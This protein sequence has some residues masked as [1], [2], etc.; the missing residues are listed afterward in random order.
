MQ[1][2]DCAGSLDFDKFERVLRRMKE[3]GGA[4]GKLVRQGGVGDGEGGEEEVDGVHGARGIAA[5]V[6]ERVR[7]DVMRG[8]LV[9][10]DGE[11]GVLKGR[12]LVIVEGFLLFGRSVPAVLR[13]MFDV[14]V[15]LRARYEDAKR[16][17]ERRNGYVTLEGFW[18]DPP[19]YFDKVVWPNYVAEHGGLV[20]DEE[21]KGVLE[22]SEVGGRVHFSDPGWGLEECLVWV[23]GVMRREVEAINQGSDKS[24]L[25][26]DSQSG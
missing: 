22:G 18:Q 6:V 4:V 19:G 23:L 12:K 14:K 7:G 15:L 26:S 25:N 24:G 17:R 10:E 16:R 5:D 21:G 2:W 3:G 1:D 9:D 8:W 13:D 11:G 20:G